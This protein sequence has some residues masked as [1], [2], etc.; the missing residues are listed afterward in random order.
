MTHDQAEELVFDL[1]QA[2]RNYERAE[3][4]SIRYHR[5]EYEALRDKAIALL[6]SPD[7]AQNNEQE[8]QG[9]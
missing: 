9:Q 5:Q 8:S 3:K 2:V 7:R 6:S 4:S 1:I